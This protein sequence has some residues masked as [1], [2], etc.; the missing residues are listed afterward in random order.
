MSHF[1]ISAGLTV[2]N[3]SHDS[4]VFTEHKENEQV[5]SVVMWF[6]LPITAS[7]RSSDVLF[8]EELMLD[9]AKDMLQ[10]I[11]NVYIKS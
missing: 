1:T 7:I 5:L 6:H 3:D 10:T 9:D 4:F 11:I 2:G 8:E